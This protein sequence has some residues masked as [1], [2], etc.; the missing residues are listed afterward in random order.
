MSH[1]K[2]VG[3]EHDIVLAYMEGESASK[4]SSR[5]ACSV[6]T[7]TRLLKEQNVVL[8]NASERRREYRVDETFFDEIDTEYKAYVLGMWFADGYNNEVKGQITLTLK[9]RDIL[10]VIRTAMTVEIPIF[11]N[12]KGYYTLSVASRRMSSCLARLGCTQRKTMSLEFPNDLQQ[13]LI[14]H[15][16]RGYFDG[17]G[18]IHIRK[19]SENRVI[20]ILGTESFLTSMARHLPCPCTVKQRS[21]SMIW[22][23]G[24]TKNSSI[25][26]FAEYLYLKAIIWMER[27]HS[28]FA[29]P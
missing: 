15:F 27:K 18:C 1:K 3:I 20:H 23:L 22:Y 11:Q 19:Q 16:I 7:I 6:P 13:A 9:D 25:A 26:A 5:F 14:R 8:R 24:I 4:L 29:V 17:D 12:C 21:S 28:L 10:G 2:F